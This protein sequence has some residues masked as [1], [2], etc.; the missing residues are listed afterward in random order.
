M[1][2]HDWTLSSTLYIAPLANLLHCLLSI[3]F[4]HSKWLQTWQIPKYA[5]HAFQDKLKLDKEESAFG[6]Q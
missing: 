1:D 6:V 2:L 5:T 3:T 4:L